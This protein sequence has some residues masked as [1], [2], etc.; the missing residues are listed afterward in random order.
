MESGQQFILKCTHCGAEM[1]FEEG[2]VIFG[3]KWFHRA[4]ASKYRFQCIQ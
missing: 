2:D 1:K 4:C 3:D